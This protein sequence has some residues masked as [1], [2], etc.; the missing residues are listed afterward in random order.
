MKQLSILLVD[1]HEVVRRGLRALLATQAGWEVVG[2][3]VNGREAVEKVNQL[4]PDVVIMDI[5]MPG[6]NGFDATRLIMEAA[7]HTKVLI[8]TMHHS[9][10]MVETALK[11]GA[12]GYVL[13]SEAGSDLIAALN[14]L[15]EKTTFIMP[16][17]VRRLPRTA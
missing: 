8:F 5:T 17:A 3:A 12:R 15:S 2:E 14:A 13:K 1:D 16:Q 7:P 6:I 10:Q 4:K 9:E 11:V